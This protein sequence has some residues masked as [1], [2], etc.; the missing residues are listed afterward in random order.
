ML[1]LNDRNQDKAHEDQKHQKNCHRPA[2]A[3]DG[4]LLLGKLLLGGNFRAPI[5]IP[6]DIGGAAILGQLDDG[7][8]P[9]RIAVHLLPAALT[10]RLVTFPAAFQTFQTAALLWTHDALFYN[11]FNNS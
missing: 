6:P 11:T 7:A 2:Q 9:H 8:G 1:V 4:S 10:K 3:A 5:G